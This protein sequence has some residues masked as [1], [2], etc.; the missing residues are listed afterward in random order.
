MN[1][2]GKKNFPDGEIFTGPEEMVTG[3]WVNFTYPAIYLQHEVDGVHLEF[4][5]GKVVKATA[6]KGEDYLLNILDTDEGSRTL[7]EFAIGT[8]KAIK[9]FTRNILFDEKLGGTIHM[10]LGAAYPDTG[11]LNHS[12][13]HWDMICETRDGTEITVDGVPFYRNGEFLIN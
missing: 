5:Q 12:A 8:N 1:S 7:G 2:E 11:G 13:V 9:Q 10:A 3:G 4:E 6:E